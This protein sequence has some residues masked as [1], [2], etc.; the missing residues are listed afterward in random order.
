MVLTLAVLGSVAVATLPLWYLLVRAVGGLDRAASI[1]GRPGF[2]TAALTSLALAVVVGAGA[3]VVGTATAWIVGRTRLRGRRAW[4]VLLLLPLAVPSYVAAY[5]W[6]S[7]A[8]WFS[9]FWA[10]ALVLVASTAPYVALPVFAALSRGEAGL[11]EVARSLGAGP[12]EVL[13]TVTLPAVRPAALAGTLLAMLYALSDFGAVAILRV[14]TL[15]RSVY[16]SY[17]SAF[18]RTAAVLQSLVLIACAV[19][20]VL[21]EQRLRGRTGS[22]VSTSVPRPVPAA[23]LPAAGRIAALAL[24]VGTVVLSL[25][26][27]AVALVLRLLQGMR[28]GVDGGELV[29]A[30]AGSAWVALLGT[31]LAVLL[32]LPVAVVAARFPGRLSRIVEVAS[33]SGHALPGV[34]VGL[35]LVFVT[36]N[37]LPALYQSVA[38][39]ALAYAVLFLPKAIG[40]SRAAIESVPVSLE[41][42]SR[43]SGRGPLATF[44]SVTA[45]LSAPGIAAGALLVMVTAMK[46]LPATLMLRPTGLETLATELWSRTEVAAYGAAAPYAVAL[47]ALAAVPATLLARGVRLPDLA[48]TDGEVTR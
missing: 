32:A 12:M 23:G 18:D 44:V 20:L 11:E 28:G 47:V 6:V 8:P 3:L 38:A 4:A 22:R 36:L 43:A 15:T 48:T 5:G 33:F 14:D 41:H 24:L 40:S 25:A 31:V 10:A 13:R 21:A 37:A 19:V 35:S 46:E 2:G 39:L 34:V 42:V 26:V 30:L 7:L 29:S 9:G 16:A 27:P 17:S 1:L 45:R